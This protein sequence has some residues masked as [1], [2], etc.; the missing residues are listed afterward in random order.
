METD[1][2][3]EPESWIARAMYQRNNQVSGEDE[4]SSKRARTSSDADEGNF[5]PV[6]SVLRD[7]VQTLKTNEMLL[8]AFRFV[9]VYREEV[10]EQEDNEAKQNALEQMDAFIETMWGEAGNLRAYDSISSELAME[11]TRYLLNQGREDEA[12][13]TIRIYCTKRPSS[14]TSSNNPFASAPVDA[15]LLWASL[16]ASSLIKQKNILERA[17][18]SIS[19][20]T[21]PDYVIA[22]LQYLGIELK[23]AS[24]TNAGNDATDDDSDDDDSSD[25][26]SDYDEGTNEAALFGTLQKLLL[27]SPKTTREVCIESGSTG[28]DFEIEDVVSAYGM[29]LE[30]FYECRGLDGAR[31]I[32]EAVLF[33]STATSTVSEDN[34]EQLKGFVD[35]CLEMEKEGEKDHAG[36]KQHKLKILRKLYDKAIDIFSGTPLEDSYREERNENS[37][38]A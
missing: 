25:D 10:E 27:L 14:G 35:R 24:K 26:N 16:S 37:I 32:Y 23:L 38:F 33:R 17:L 6:I 36:G 22:L 2:A 4:P 34:V 13:Q 29:C 9:I 12:L 7:A 1:F 18:E 3:K 21:H 5:D 31:T 15:W 8:Q 11:Q 20:D 19:I 30:H 28:L